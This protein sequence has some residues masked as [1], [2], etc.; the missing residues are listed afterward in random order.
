[1]FCQNIRKI[2][3]IKVVSVTVGHPVSFSAPVHARSLASFRGIRA[4]RHFLNNEQ[5]DVQRATRG[6]D[7]GEKGKGAS[8]ITLRRD[9]CT[10]EHSTARETRFIGAPGRNNIPP[11]LTRRSLRRKWAPFLRFFLLLCPAKGGF[12]PTGTTACLLTP[13]HEGSWDA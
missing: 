5:E 4:T 11:F 2:F 7:D 13:E 10:H 3:Q 1:M 6:E 12:C 8:L 9:I